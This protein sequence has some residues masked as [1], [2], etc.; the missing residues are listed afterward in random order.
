MTK[1]AL[2]GPGPASSLTVHGFRLGAQGRRV[3]A[4][5]AP[6]TRQ[7]GLRAPL[8]SSRRRD[9]GQ[10]A[11]VAGPRLTCKDRTGITHPWG[12]VR[13]PCDAPGKTPS[14]AADPVPGPAAS[15]TPKAR[16]GQAAPGPGVP[17]LASAGPRRGPETPLGA[18][19]ARRPRPGPP[20]WLGASARA[21]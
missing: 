13:A 21:A 8:G 16:P 20:P 17:A 7:S 9:L 14:T 19:G 4:R 6:R 15:H 3:R 10:G 1:G 18:P 2:P 11:A 5:A 12:L